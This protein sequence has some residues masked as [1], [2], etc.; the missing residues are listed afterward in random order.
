MGKL[1]FAILGW[2]ALNASL[3]VVL[4][5]RRHRPHL[6]NRLFRWVIGES[7]A[8]NSKP[9]VDRTDKSATSS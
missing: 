9:Q 7:G 3:P 4:L 2:L 1:L 6:Q 8:S 5:K